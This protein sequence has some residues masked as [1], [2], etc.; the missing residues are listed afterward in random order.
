ML[1]RKPLR[2]HKN[3]QIFLIGEILIVSA[4]TINVLRQH[5]LPGWLRLNSLN[6]L[7]EAAKKDPVCTG[8]SWSDRRWEATELPAQ[9][10]G[11]IIA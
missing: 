2:L 4:L 11:S 3:V 9:V 5:L 7:P 10:F 6:L 1:S 8:Q